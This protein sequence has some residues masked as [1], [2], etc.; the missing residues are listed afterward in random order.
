M[1]IQ[2]MLYELHRLRICRTD[3][4]HNNY[5]NTIDQGNNT[6][7]FSVLTEVLCFLV[8]PVVFDGRVVISVTTI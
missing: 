8:S 7:F 6:I 5:H 2:K 1:F 3:I 4:F